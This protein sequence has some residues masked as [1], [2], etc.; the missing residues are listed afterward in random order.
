MKGS[1][2]KKV[3]GSNKVNAALFLVFFIIGVA[4]LAWSSTEAS[5]FYLPK[6]ASEHGILTDNLFWLIT[7]IILVV[8]FVT[9][10]LLFGFA[11]FYQ[12]NPNRKA[13]FYPENHKLEIIWTI[14]PAIVLTILVFMGW[15]TW[16][17]ITGP[18]PSN[19]VV[20]EITGKQ[21]NWIVRY[22]GKDNKLGS[23]I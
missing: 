6:S 20:L 22:P 13:L 14:I 7:C 5:K 21:F 12:Y 16:T 11:F 19:A 4:L 1:Y 3:S 9:N 2:N 8:F 17:D 18:A 15:R 10:L 23:Y